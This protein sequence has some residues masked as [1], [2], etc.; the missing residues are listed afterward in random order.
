MQDRNTNPAYYERATCRECDTDQELVIHKFNGSV[1]CVHCLN[2][3]INE[4]TRFEEMN[5]EKDDNE[6]LSITERNL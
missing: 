1:L 3:E 2:S 6:A 4:L 5:N